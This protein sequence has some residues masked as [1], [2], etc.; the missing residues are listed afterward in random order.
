[1]LRHYQSEFFFVSSACLVRAKEESEFWHFFSLTSWSIVE[2]K[3][4]RAFSLLA[5][6]PCA[7]LCETT[8]HRFGWLG[9]VGQTSLNIGCVCKRH[10]LRYCEPRSCHLGLR[11]FFFFFLLIFMGNSSLKVVK[12]VF[13]SY[14]VEIPTNTVLEVRKVYK[15]LKLL[16]I[17]KFRSKIGIGKEIRRYWDSLGP[18]GQ[19]SQNT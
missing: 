18:D 13:T 19:T 3:L 5:H 15:L 11:I 4:T 8:I 14:L 10:F 2:S 12:R 1:V 9:F 17:T 7:E 6:T 16:P